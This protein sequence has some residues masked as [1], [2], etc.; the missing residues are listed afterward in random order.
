[1]PTG[2]G[3][4][5]IYAILAKYFSSLGKTV[6]VIVPNENLRNQTA[7]LIGVS[8][9]NLTVCTIKWFYEHPNK[10]E[11]VII[12]EY[13]FIFQNLPFATSPIGISGIWSLQGRKAF[14]FSATSSKILERI[15]D[16]IF[17]DHYMLKFSSEFEIVN[18]C[19][20]LE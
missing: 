16:K 13:D 17:Q 18:K 7:D 1:M 14:F 9:N 15:V 3:K 6:T 5:W 2:S 19:T 4:T 10:D 11:I 20:N 12:D 8:D